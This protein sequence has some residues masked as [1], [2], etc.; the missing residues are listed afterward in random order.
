MVSF[1]VSSSAV[2]VSTSAEGSNEAGERYTIHCM[3]RTPNVLSVL[4]DITWIN[5]NGVEIHHQVNN[6]IVGSLIVIMSTVT[7]TPLLTSQS[8]IY[9]CQVSLQSPSLSQPLNMSDMV[10]VSVQSKF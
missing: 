7:F 8:G 5:P 1:L 9:M 6:T 2:S 10:T 4:P 3:V